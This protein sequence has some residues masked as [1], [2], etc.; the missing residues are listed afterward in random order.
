MTLKSTTLSFLFAT[1]LITSGCA[2]GIMMS[3]VY[4]QSLTYQDSEMVPTPESE[5]IEIVYFDDI[6]REFEVIGEIVI[7]GAAFVS[8]E[9][10]QDELFREARA[11]GADA[12]TNFANSQYREDEIIGDGIIHVGPTETIW[13]A[14]AI[15]WSE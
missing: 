11:M 7:I 1:L 5:P 9:K 2:P 14:K 3:K 4:T 6:E 8:S 10:M 15:I 12:L 13:K